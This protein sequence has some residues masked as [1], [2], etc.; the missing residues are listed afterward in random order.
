MGNKEARNMF[1]FPEVCEHGSKESY[2]LMKGGIVAERRVT[3]K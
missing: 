1:P 2:V 3:R